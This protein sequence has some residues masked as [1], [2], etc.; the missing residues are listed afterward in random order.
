MSPRKFFHSISY[1]QYPLIVLALFFAVQPYLGGL[2]SAFEDFNTL[3]QSIN[4]TFIFLGL[5]ISFST[6]QDTTKTQNKF[7]R[8][9][10]QDPKKSRRFLAVFSITILL[11]LLVGVFAYLSTSESALK[12]VSFGAIVLGIGMIGMLK[13]AIEMAEYHGHRALTSDAGPNSAPPADRSPAD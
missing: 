10:W 9:I 6:L 5:G 7:S 1:L 12:E 2:Q 11:V 13:G 4:K 8:Q 3:L